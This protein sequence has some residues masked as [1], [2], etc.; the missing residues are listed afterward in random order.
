[1]YNPCSIF[2]VLRTDILNNEYLFAQ[3][4]VFKVL[5]A[6]KKQVI[7]SILKMN[8]LIIF[9]IKDSLT[10]FPVNYCKKNVCALKLHRIYNKITTKT[11]TETC[12][13]CDIHVSHRKRVY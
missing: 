9:E 12:L 1:M 10:N 5:T 6:W 2:Y 4:Y 3:M 13:K 7:L 8:P 11:T